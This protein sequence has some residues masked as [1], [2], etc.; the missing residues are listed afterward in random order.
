MQCHKL[1]GKERRRK[2]LEIAS[3]ALIIR[4]MKYICGEKGLT[5]GSNV[6]F[7]QV[8]LVDMHE[9]G[10]ESDAAV[11]QGISEDD[12]RIPLFGIRDTELVGSK[13]FDDQPVPLKPF[14][15]ADHSLDPDD[16]PVEDADRVPGGHRS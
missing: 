16:A 2:G 8:L 10:V 3:H 12:P 7:S 5:F 1:T 6:H 9:G 14:V 4:M 15:P 11:G 13:A